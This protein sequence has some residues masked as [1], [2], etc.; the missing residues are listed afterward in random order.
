MNSRLYVANVMH[1]RFAPV[2]HRF[3]YPVFTF[4]FDLD[5]LPTLD[6]TVRGF[7]YNRAALVSLHDPDYLR[8][9][10][11]IRERLCPFLRQAG[12]DDI[13]RVEVLTMPRMFGHVFNPVSFYYAYRADGSIRCV[14][15]EVNNT[16]GER[17]LY[18]MPVVGGNPTEFPLRLRHDKQFHVSPFNNMHGRYE[19]RL[20]DLGP[21]LRVEIDLIRDNVRVMTAVLWGQAVPLDSRSLLAHV[22]RHPFRIVANLPRI[23]WQACLLRYRRR[24]AFHHKPNPSHPMTIGIPRPSWRQR[25]CMAAVARLLGSI[26]TGRLFMLLPDGT[27]ASFG[28]PRADPCTLRV[29]NYRFFTRVVFGGDV[30]FGESYVDG[31]W[32]ADDLS[33]LMSLLVHN[34]NNLD[35]AAVNPGLAGRLANRILHF[36]RRNTVQRSRR[37]I[38]EHYDL[39]ND[40]YRLW[41]DPETLFYSSAVFET[42][43]QS[44]AEAQRAK[45]GRI[46]DL[47]GIGP[48]HHVLEIG[49]G[50]GGFAIEAVRRTGCR[51]TGITISEAQ[52]RLARERVAEA[53][54]QDRI[55]LRC[56]DYRHLTGTFDRIVSIEMI[57]A[58]G[59]DYLG[60]FFQRCAAVLAPDGRLVLQAITI[61]DERY[62]AYRRSPDW[63]QK[64][65][66]PGGHLPSRAILDAA[67]APAGLRVVRAENIGPH[68]ATTLRAWRERFNAV[69]AEL[70]RQGFD[71]AFQR[72]WNYYFTYCEAGFAAHYIDDWHLAIER[73]VSTQC[74]PTPVSR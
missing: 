24:L 43:G 40:F 13:A 19:F 37:N 8:G 74:R 41:L 20:S 39:G 15:A 23:A 48:N 25:L 2:A 3:R 42:P 17:H 45:V 71:E 47:A 53:G 50:W 58:V 9:E 28:D 18:V 11:T 60:A 32:T 63:I 14:V 65:I 68:Y 62:D 44:L 49:C 69:S 67:M 61:P 55:E 30:G 64:H 26:R 7:G 35:A 29:W 31:D 12:C 6:R 72:K 5:E 54:L 70:A 46:L 66:F 21:S 22:L 51:V 59:H 10:G 16:F 34:V 33:A 1:A 57:E 38:R 4:A 56:Q 73:P 27:T 36:S 52:L